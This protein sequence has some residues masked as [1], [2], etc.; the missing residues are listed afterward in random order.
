[1]RAP[2]RTIT[3][4]IG[5]LK[6]KLGNKLTE[7]DGEYF[8]TIETGALRL[9]DLIEDLL[10]YSKVNSLALN[11]SNFS[12]RDL[13]NEVFE[14]LSFQIDKN[15]IEVKN[16]E[17][18]T[19]LFADRT[20]IK[21]ILQNLIDNAVK[22]QKDIVNAAVEVRSH[23]DPTHY[24]ISVSDRGI[25]IPEEYIDKIFG[26]FTQLNP[27][28]AYEGTG[29]GLAICQEY[30]KKHKGEIAAKNNSDQGMTFTFSISKK[31][32]KEL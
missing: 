12:L 19:M 9:N 24:Y 11:I 1:M 25:G 15:N 8:N 2:L 18:E 32:E 31:L 6:K 27:K 7:A 26:K 21:Q 29:L 5:L 22:F 13:V 23:Q 16:L 28:D 4:Y 20:M 10:E 30:I 3:S 17:S 14:N